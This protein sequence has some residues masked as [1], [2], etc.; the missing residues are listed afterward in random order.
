MNVKAVQNGRSLA[1]E[2]KADN[3]M[4]ISNKLG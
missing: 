3:R 1:A 2:R 4:R